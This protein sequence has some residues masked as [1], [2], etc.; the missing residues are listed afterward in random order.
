MTPKELI[1]L[2][3]ACRRAGIK[4]YR[5]GDIEF[6]LDELDTTPVSKASQSEEDVQGKIETPD[7]VSD[8][9]LLFWSVLTSPGSEPS[10]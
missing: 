10:Q 1:K 4:H 8:Q 7:E 3:Q 5:C 2:A 9:D 6:T